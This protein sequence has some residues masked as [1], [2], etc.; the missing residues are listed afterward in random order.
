VG[1]FE[2]GIGWAGANLWVINAVCRDLKRRFE[3]WSPSFRRPY[4][5][6]FMAFR[7]SGTRKA[8][9]QMWLHLALCCFRFWASP[10][11]EV[12]R[13]WAAHVAVRGVG[14]C[15]GRCR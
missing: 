10:I 11:T 1:A 15:I 4:R 6:L 8:I 2:V 9:G 12:L 14:L 3:N 5:M 7:A 13:D